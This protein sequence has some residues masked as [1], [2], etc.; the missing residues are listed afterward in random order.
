MFSNLPNILLTAHLKQPTNQSSTGF[1]HVKRRSYLAA[2][3]SEGRPNINLEI[4]RHIDGILDWNVDCPEGK[5]IIASF[6]IGR[7]L[8]KPYFRWRIKALPCLLYFDWNVVEESW[9]R[10][11]YLFYQCKVWKFV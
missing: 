2:A 11:V 4:F 1:L 6:R 9:L 10:L 7:P 8:V 3:P 5:M